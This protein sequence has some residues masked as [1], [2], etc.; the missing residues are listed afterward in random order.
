MEKLLQ[1]KIQ[2][3]LSIIALLGVIGNVW[4]AS[5]L[6][7]FAVDISQ[8]KRDVAAQGKTLDE[9]DPYIERFIQLEQRD[10]ILVEDVSSIVVDL[11][12]MN[13]K[14]DKVLDQHTELR[15]KINGN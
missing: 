3:L 14:L 12:A 7:P 6:S 13:A 9:I 10:Q 5:K 2:L 8:V 1:P 15:L 4:I 11:K